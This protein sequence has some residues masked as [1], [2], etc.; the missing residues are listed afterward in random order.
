MSR[1]SPLPPGIKREQVQ[2]SSLAAEWL[3][4][5]QPAGA[6][7]YL[8]GG[9]YALGSI[10]THRSL[11]AALAQ[12][13]G[14]QV[15]LPGYRLAPEH[16]FPAALDD[17]VRAY[18][19]LQESGFMPGEIILGGDSAGGGLA[20]ALLAHLRTENEPMPAGAFLLSPWADLTLSG[21][22]MTKNAGLDQVLNPETLSR[23]AGMYAG[24]HDRNNTKISPLYAPMDDLPPL[25]VQVGTDEI[26]LDDAVRL[27][28][29]VTAAA[30]DL[31]LEVYPGMFHVF[32]M[33]PFLPESR[34]ALVSIGR[35]CREKF[36][37]IG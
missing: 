37:T 29:K 34:E 9:A 7:L 33:M 3:R 27:A 18:H 21:S 12:H 8:H 32:Q 28:E 30:G 2:I 19:W 17:A 10:T 5:S 1:W 20:L 14:M 35:F 25:L 36:Q 4:P 6:M 13:T 23:F 26:L 16:P 15:L 24:D 22:S 11:A 31:R